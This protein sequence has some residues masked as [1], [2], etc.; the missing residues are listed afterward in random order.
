MN[1][2]KSLREHCSLKKHVYV[3]QNTN[4]RF[5]MSRI[6]T[7]ILRLRDAGET[8]QPANYIVRESEALSLGPWAPCKNPDIY[9]IQG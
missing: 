5:I 3:N 9:V 2:M 1:K 8:A 6:Y 4:Y 7:Y